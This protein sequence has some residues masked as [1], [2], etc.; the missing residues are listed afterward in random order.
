MSHSGSPNG[1]DKVF[2]SVVHGTMWENSYGLP[3]GPIWVI[4]GNT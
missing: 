1:I 3:G 4:M 2:A